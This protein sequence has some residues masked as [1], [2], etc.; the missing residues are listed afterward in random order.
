M[1]SSPLSCTMLT[2]PAEEA[3]KPQ[4]PGARRAAYSPTLIKSFILLKWIQVGG[5]FNSY[6]VYMSIRKKSKTEGI[7][8][9]PLLKDIVWENITLWG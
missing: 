8:T 7:E 9:G 4:H 1:H 6:L 2:V 3:K 5:R